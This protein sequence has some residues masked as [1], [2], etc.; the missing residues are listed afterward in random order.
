MKQDRLFRKRTHTIIALTIVFC[1]GFSKD[2]YS[3]IDPGTGSYFIQL[4]L[5]AL[6]GG[7]FTLKIFWKKLKLSLR[8]MVQKGKK[9]GKTGDE[10]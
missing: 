5:A 4:L 1:L 8:K 7:L 6:V 9:Y 3:Y 2:S 10:E